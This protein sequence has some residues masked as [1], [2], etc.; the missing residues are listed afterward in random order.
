[1]KLHEL[2]SVLANHLNSSPRF[3]LPGG[4]QIPAHA[5]VTEVGYSEK[6]FIDCGGVIGK[7]EA[8]LL[9]THVGNDTEHRL[10]A[11]RFHKILQLDDRVLPHD[12]LDV[13]IE[14]DCCVVARYPVVEAKANGA[15]LDL[16]LA[17]KRTQCLARE[18][19]KDETAA[20]CYGAP[21]CC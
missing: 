7:S 14:Y 2:R 19:A 1:M 8:V 20:P 13:E 3:I 17:N 18:R 15:N 9:Q 11:A 12:R 6:N 5:H 10:T 21:S 4:D 16:I